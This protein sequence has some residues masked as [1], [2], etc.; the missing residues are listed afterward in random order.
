MG[1]SY[2]I[3]IIF[4]I[5]R[6]DRSILTTVPGASDPSTPPY[7]FSVSNT[8]RQ[9]QTSSTI[10]LPLAGPGRWES[11]VGTVNQRNVS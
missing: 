5:L 1:F 10:N 4:L 11:P 8:A 9:I 7:E 2:S 6:A 3:A